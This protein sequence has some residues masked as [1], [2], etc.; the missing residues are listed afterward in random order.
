MTNRYRL[1]LVRWEDSVV[2]DSRWVFM[3]EYEP[4]S[5]VQ[6]ESVGWL[7]SDLPGQLVLAPNIGDTMQGQALQMS[8]M[9]RIPRRS[10]VSVEDI[11][12]RAPNVMEGA[13]TPNIIE[14]PLDTRE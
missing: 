12:T 4:D 2:P 11:V 13:R 5:C 14:N 7:V 3:H 9:I 6:C 8:G 10:I 1:V